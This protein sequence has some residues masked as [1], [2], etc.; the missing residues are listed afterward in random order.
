MVP[1]VDN[2]IVGGRTQ[3]LNSY[4]MNLDATSKPLTY[5]DQRG[6][7]PKLY[8]RGSGSSVVAKVSLL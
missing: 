5:I 4:Q 8:I 2:M 7:I 6:H 1:F 3:L